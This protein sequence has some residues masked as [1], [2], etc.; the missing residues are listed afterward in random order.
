ME[1]TTTHN[2]RNIFYH[3]YIHFF[4][5]IVST[6]C[7]KCDNCAIVRCAKLQN[8]CISEKWVMCKWDFTR[9]D[10]VWNN[11]IVQP[12]VIIIRISSLVMKTGTL[13]LLQLFIMCFAQ[14]RYIHIWNKGI[15]HHGI[16]GELGP[17]LLTHSLTSQ[18]PRWRLKSPASWLFTQSFIR[19][20]IKK[21]SKAPRHWP[22]CGEFTRTGE[23]PA[24]RA[25]NAE[26]VSIWWRHHDEWS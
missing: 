12:K 14:E 17:L 16:P 3:V 26:N 19:V 4:C 2:K 9:F 21:N 7:T 13:L 23:I 1:L 25:S 22:L 8:D 11:P 18:W 6:F 15:T 24:Q 20:Q 10:F 5:G